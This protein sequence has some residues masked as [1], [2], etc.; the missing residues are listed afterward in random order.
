MRIFIAVELP[1]SVREKLAELQEKLKVT[2]D[3]VRWVK[4]SLI[5]LTM[6]FLGEV[7]EKE[8]EK[9]IQITGNIATRFSVFKIKIGKIGMFPS[10]S[11]R[12]IWAGV[13]EGKDILEALAE[14]LERGLSKEG[15]AR[16]RKKWTPHLTLGRVKILKE[17]EKLKNLILS[18][19]EAEGGE[20]RVRELSVIQS[21]L[22][23]EGPIYTVLKRIPF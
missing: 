12:V 22:T 10:S 7:K 11:P 13:N 3:K 20:A 16:E 1:D 17:R 8:L 21:Y 6:K 4:P 9:A 5:H 14:E 18:Y 2:E 15:F 19:E 23:R